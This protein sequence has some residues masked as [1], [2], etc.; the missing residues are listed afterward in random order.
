MMTTP[1]PRAIER[2]RRAVVPPDR[3]T[4]VLAVSTLLRST[5]GGLS[6]ALLV[7]FATRWVGLSNGQLGVAMSIA[8]LFGI[9]ASVPGGYLADRTSPRNATALLGTMQGLAICAYSLTRSFPTFLAVACVALLCESA[10]GSARGALIASAV[11]SDQRV[12]L[13][14]YLRSLS[15]AG[16]SLGAAAGGVALGVGSRQVSAALIVVCGVLFVAAS[17]VLLVLP[18]T[19]ARRAHAEA[20]RGVVLRDGPFMA[21]AILNGLLITNQGLL[22]IALPLWIATRTAAP[23]ALYAA[24]IIL[25]TVCVVLFQVPVSR[26][27]ADAAGAA[28]AQRRGSVFLAACCVLFALAAGTPAWLAVT[29]LAAGALVHVVGELLQE[30]GSW[31]LSFELAPAGAQG[32]YQGMYGMTL[33]VAQAIAPA[34][35]TTVVLGIGRWGWGIFALLFVGCGLAVPPVMRWAVRTRPHY[36]PDAAAAPPT[37][38]P[39]LTAPA[40][41]TGIPQ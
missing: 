3:P 7:L 28:R 33:Q 38:T 5:G 13:R 27:A 19:S 26:G 20:R 17:L 41:N 10:N 29:I 6:V 12:R 35:V 8:A 25:N 21:L 37:I 31:G 36:A 24:L 11:P 14:A 39:D 23:T 16:V 30:A 22:I 34:L 1:Q 15:N 40:P 2:I 9:A 18:A 4:W 32:Q